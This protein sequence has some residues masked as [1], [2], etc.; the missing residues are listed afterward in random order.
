MPAPQSYRSPGESQRAPTGQPTRPITPID[1]V[2]SRLDA[3][4]ASGDGWI[5]RC[6]AHEDNAPSLSINEGSDGRALLRCFA[7]CETAA[8]CESI[9]FAVAD[10]F[11][12]DGR[13]ATTAY[14]RGERI[15]FDFHDASGSLTYQEVRD[16]PKRFW[17]RRPDGRGGWTK[18]LDGVQRELYRL[19]ELLAEPDRP[20]ALVE[21]CKD[22][23]R[24]R[25]LGIVATTVA[26]GAKAPWIDRFSETLAGRAV[27]VLADNDPPGIACAYARA[28]ALHGI[29]STVKMIE[30]PGLPAKGDVSDWLDSGHTKDELVRIVN[31]AP[32]WS[33]VADDH[34]P[35]GPAIVRADAL[36]AKVF[37]EPRWAVEGLF[38]E[39]LTLLVGAPKLGK[40][41]L[42]LNIAVAVATG[43]VA[44]GKIPV[45]GGDVLYLA[46]EDT[47]RR[48]Q[49]RL[50]ITLQGEPAPSRLHIA[51]EWPTLADGAAAH[52]R[53]WLERHPDA[54][55][56]IVDTFQRLRGPVSGNQNLYAGDYA[57]AGELKLVADRFGVALVAVHHTRKATADD[58]LDMVSGTAGLAGV[59]DTTLV[60]RKEIG[61]A[62]GTLYCRGRDVPEADHALTFD[63]EACAWSL[64]GDAATYRRSRERQDIIALLDGSPEPMRPKAIADALGKKDGAI[65]YLLHRMVKDGE[66]DGLGGSYRLPLSP[67]NTPNAPNAGP[68]NPA[69]PGQMAKRAVSGAPL[70]PNSPSPSVRGDVPAPNTPLTAKPPERWGDSAPVRAV[71]T[72]RG[73]DFDRPPGAIWFCADCEEP[74]SR[75]PERCPRCGATAGH[76]LT[77]EEL[78]S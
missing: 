16:P 78:A 36:M 72:V 30:L 41:W 13:P 23:D 69:I 58:P 40:S 15:T 34:D 66:I 54:R 76:W 26:G 8:I 27:V 65:R 37:P 57:T 77:P 24:L 3:V 35:I 47:G 49:E 42:A 52:L 10:L 2:L 12:R 55:L 60:L 48:M 18:G 39:G 11:V 56:V 62:D 43:G 59:A 4:K 1:R 70:T 20:V 5:A 14:A 74:R 25:N 33:P 73:T 51:T 6:P 19:P 67:P 31:D 61:R 17:L 21:G 28:E 22:A 75:G 68:E 71:R 50:G 64:L 7:G 53:Q 38:P 32:A 44:V 46:L 45:D 63:P 29:A 9:G